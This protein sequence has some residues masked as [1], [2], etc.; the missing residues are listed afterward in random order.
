M[1]HQIFTTTPTLKIELIDTQ[2]SLLLV[3]DGLYWQSLDAL[4]CPVYYLE[5]DAKTRG[6]TPHPQMQPINHTQWVEMIDN[7]EKLKSWF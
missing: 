5:D 6:I 4:P 1:I 2:D 3:G 7:A